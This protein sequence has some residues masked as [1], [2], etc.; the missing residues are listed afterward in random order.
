M[1]DEKQIISQILDGD[2]S[3]FRYFVD[4]YQNLVFRVVMG[5][6]HDKEEAK[7]ISQEVFLKAF[8]ALN[9]FKGDSAFSTW[10]YR[11]SITTSLTH[12]AKNKRKNAIISTNEISQTI[13]NY[14]PSPEQCI[15]N[16]EVRMAIKSALDSLCE[17]QKTAFILQKYEGL[18]QQ[19]IA[20]IMKTTE[21]S[22]E[23]HLQRAKN[24]L[25]KKLYY[26]VG[27]DN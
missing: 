19:E 20:E 6:V 17:K 16:E 2:S 13:N 12:L 15:E 21:G 25:K 3:A 5:F 23:Q 7:D 18:S 10:L 4:N 24:N 11:I 9:K 1:T 8:Q 14:T 22:V 27:N 26:L